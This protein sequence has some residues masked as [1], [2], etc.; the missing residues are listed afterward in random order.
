MELNSEHGKLDAKNV[1]DQK[2]KD[3]SC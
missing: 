1:I 2:M 3:H